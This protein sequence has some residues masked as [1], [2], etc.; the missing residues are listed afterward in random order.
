MTE[1]SY[2]ALLSLKEEKLIAGA[3]KLLWRSL[4]RSEVSKFFDS[5]DFAMFSIEKN[6]KKADKY[7]KLLKDIIQYFASIEIASY[8]SNAGYTYFKKDL[9]KGTAKTFG[10]FY[11]PPSVLSSV[12]KQVNPKAGEKTLDPSSGSCSFIQEAATKLMNIDGL[13]VEEAFENL[14]GVEVEPN[15]YQ[16]GAMNIFL[17]FG[18]LPNTEQ[19]IREDDSLLLLLQE[20]QKFDK[21]LANPPFGA[22]ASSFFGMYFKDE[23]VKK[24]KRN[25]TTKV[26]NPDVKVKIPF[27]NTK[28]SAILFFQLIIQKLVDGG[29]AGVVMSSTILNDGNKDMIKWFLE[30]CSLEKIIINPAGTF[31]DQGTGIE[32]FSFIFT[33]G[34]PTTK[35]DIVMLGSEEEVI[36]SLTLDQIKEA[37]WKL[38]LKEEEKKVEYTGEYELKKLGD[39]CDLLSGKTNN[40]RGEGD[41][42][43]YDSN[44]Q[45]AVVKDHLYDGEFVITARVLSIGSVNYVSGKFWA[46][47]NTINIRVKD[48]ALLSTRFFYNWLNSNTQVLKALSSGIKPYI[49]KSDLAE[50]LMPLPPLP[51]QQEIVAT[52]DR[53]FADPQDMKDCLAFTDKAMDLMLKDPSGKLVEDVMG[54]LRLKRSHLAA[55]AST[56]AQMAAV[57]RSVGARGFE[58]KKVEDITSLKGGFPFKSSD[59]VD[60][61]LAVLKHN[62]LQNGSVEVS[63][64]QDYIK[65]TTE[66]DNYLLRSG[67]LVV[68]MDFDCGKIGK[69]LTD[70]WVLNQRMTLVRT[71]DTN[72][73][74]QEYLYWLLRYGGF[75]EAL[76]NV[77]TG[78]TI[79]HISGKNIAD[80]LLDI[81]PLPIQQEVL[82]SLNEMEAELKVMEQMAAKAEQRAKYILDGYLTAS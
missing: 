46:G 16:E 35:V 78:T 20:E 33:K 11:T 13:S 17:N 58:K 34:A 28:E 18:I 14:Y 24:G 39:V 59:Y 55:A 50:V 4:Q 82:A 60:S 30:C 29:K 79:K 31:K 37:G 52:L 9:N 6:E 3:F 40:Y 48:S 38:Q 10:Q 41:I 27:T 19:N 25:V 21:I 66:M 44:G 1:V 7:F 2:K 56:K 32:T 45:I 61:G 36:R 47:D 73:I 81:P 5:R 65:Q 23:T 64:G 72:V 68:S 71:K 70:G 42:P 26:V 67:D 43:F 49:R 15:I 12:V 75:Y 53:I 80:V 22:D 51:T 62:N 69:I 76:Q 77:H 54:G 74:S 63:K 8:D 57:M